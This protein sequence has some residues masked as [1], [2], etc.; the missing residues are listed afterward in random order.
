MTEGAE[1]KP[2]D[3]QHGP[4]EALGLVE[5]GAE[6]E[7]SS[8]GEPYPDGM[9]ICYLEGTEALELRRAQEAPDGH[10][11]P[12]KRISQFPR[13]QLTAPPGRTSL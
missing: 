6:H 12:G 11:L 13:P 8:A 7:V 9:A 10:E 5:A 3:I 2:T 4:G 1:G